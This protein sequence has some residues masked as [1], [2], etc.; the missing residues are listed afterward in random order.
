M[1][2]EQNRCYVIIEFSEMKNS[3]QWNFPKFTYRF[4][5]RNVVPVGVTSNV[6]VAPS[7]IG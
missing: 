5:M 1:L 7:I 2:I 6:V 3:L 4:S